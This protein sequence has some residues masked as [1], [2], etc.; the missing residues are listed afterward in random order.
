MTGDMGR[1]R[2]LPPEEE[3]AEPAEHAAAGREPEPEPEP[4]RSRPGSRAGTVWSVLTVLASTALLVSA[5]LPWAHLEMTTELLG[6]SFSDDLGSV[7]G[8]DADGTV[9]V[10]PVLALAAAVVALWGAVVR[11]VR[12]SALA[13]LPGALA[14]VACVLFALR[15]RRTGDRYGGDGALL[16]SHTHAAL[17][18]GWYLGVGA[19]LL[20][21]GVGLVRPFARRPRGRGTDGRPPPPVIPE[22]PDQS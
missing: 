14:L 20:V 4:A 9:V 21:V 3:P 22:G 6:T 13:A 11:D 18:Y 7:A 1:P 10:V 16:A 12:I 2:F 8:I 17:D 5:F 19:A 15:L